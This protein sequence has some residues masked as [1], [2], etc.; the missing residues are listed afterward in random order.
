[1]WFNRTWRTT[2]TILRDEGLVIIHVRYIRLRLGS[3]P[4][5]HV[6][7][8]PR[9]RTHAHGTYAAPRGDGGNGRGDINGD[10]RLQRSDAVVRWRVPPTQCLPVHEGDCSWGM[11]QSNDFLCPFNDAG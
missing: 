4:Q 9:K 10:G 1:M 8:K 6:A 7:T 5:T 11:S 3:Q 2:L